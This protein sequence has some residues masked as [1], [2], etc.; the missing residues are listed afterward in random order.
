[1]RRI[2]TALFLMLVA[3]PAGAQ[4]QLEFNLCRDKDAD[5]S[6]NGCTALIQKGV[7]RPEIYQKRGFAYFDKGRYRD[8]IAD[9]SKVLAL[10]PKYY[11]VY[12]ARGY[13][14]EKNGQRAE[15]IADYRKAV[16]LNPASSPEAKASQARLNVLSH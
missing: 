6:I 7:N 11:S 13:S 12:M 15:A 9:L 16:K 10:D 14:Y 2:L 3:V 1:M 4:S 5:L 8:A